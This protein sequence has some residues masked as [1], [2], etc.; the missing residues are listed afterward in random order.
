MAVEASHLRN[1][2]YSDRSERVCC[3][4]QDLALCDIS[5]EDIVCGALETEECDIS[6]HKITFQCS[7]CYFF[8]KCSC[9]DLLVFH[10]VAA[11]LTGSC[12]STV[13]CHKCIFLGVVVF[14]LDVFFVHISR[15]RIIDI[16]K[17][18][19][20]LADYCSDELAECT[21]NVYFT[22]YRNASCCQTAVYIAWYESELCLECRPAF[23]GDC[24]IFAV[25][26]VFLNPV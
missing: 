1:C 17:C 11:Q 16:K 8:R 4:R 3:Y 24:H 23:S 25:A 6:W 26:F 13:E 19:C 2:E 14:V 7:L 18:D 20:V 5:A 12:I 22:G 10:L 9:H 21:V 15:H